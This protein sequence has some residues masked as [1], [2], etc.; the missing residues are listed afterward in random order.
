MTLFPRSCVWESIDMNEST[1]LQCSLVHPMAICEVLCSSS[2]WNLSVIE[3]YPVF[4]A[5][6]R[7]L[8][9]DRPALGIVLAL[10]L[11]NIFFACVWGNWQD[12]KNV[13]LFLRSR[14]FEDLEHDAE[15]QNCSPSGRYLA[16][17]GDCIFSET[18]PNSKQFDLLHF[19]VFVDFSLNVLNSPV[20]I[21]S[22][23][24]DSVL[25]VFTKSCILV[26]LPWSSGTAFSG[27]P[28]TRRSILKNSASAQDCSLLDCLSRSTCQTFFNTIFGGGRGVRI[29]WCKILSPQRLTTYSIQSADTES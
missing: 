8:W 27:T 11:V 20:L 10:H 13:R 3:S 28:C 15:V 18:S 26:T 23:M 5:L 17:D 29:L 12:F 9:S 4:I 24:T 21:K 16:K 22:A 19:L 1:I 25:S 2:P 6:T 7:S 14:S